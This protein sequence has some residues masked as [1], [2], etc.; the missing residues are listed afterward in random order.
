MKEKGVSIAKAAAG[1]IMPALKKYCWAFAVLLAGVLL[2][3]SGGSCGR[4][5]EKAGGGVEQASGGFD[6]ASF[7]SQLTEKLEAINGVG[8]VSL[9]LSLD[10]TE[11][12]VYA[13]NVRRSDGN[14]Q[15]YESDLAVL[16]DGS[17]GEEPVTLKRLLPSFRGAVVLCEGA[18]DVNV[19]LAVTNAVSTVCGIGSDKVTVLKMASGA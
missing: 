7:E 1:S 18:D 3:A 2:L 19:R 6:L 13:V 15:S 4:V 9:M 14:T 8:K 5:Q 12:A 17:Y 10:E 11:E 16:S